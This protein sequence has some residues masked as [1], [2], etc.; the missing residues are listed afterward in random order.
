MISMISIFKKISQHVFNTPTPKVSWS[1]PHICEFFGSNIE[2]RW[3]ASWK[4]QIYPPNRLKE[5]LSTRNVFENQNRHFRWRN[6]PNTNIKCCFH[7]IDD[8]S[9]SLY[10]NKKQM[11]FCGGGV[12]P[13][14]LPVHQRVV[15]RR[16][17]NPPCY[18]LTGTGS[19]ICTNGHT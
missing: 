11:A 8:N 9:A 10:K 15:R 4:L 7:L 16:V 5:T 19:P 6:L 17:F 14:P 18:W 3:L 13:A 1:S 12:N 2:L